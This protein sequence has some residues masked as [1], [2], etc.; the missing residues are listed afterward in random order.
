MVAAPPRRKG[1]CSEPAFTLVERRGSG[2]KGSAFQSI[3]ISG[4]VAS[5]LA[6]STI[7]TQGRW[8]ER[9]RRRKQSA[10]GSGRRRRGESRPRSRRGR[11]R[12]RPRPTCPSP[13][14]S[15]RHRPCT[16]SRP[17]P[18]LPLSSRHCLAGPGPLRRA[19][20]HLPPMRGL[21]GPRGAGEGRR[22]PGGTQ[23]PAGSPGRPG[24]KHAGGWCRPFPAGLRPG[25][26]GDPGPLLA[27][28]PMSSW[29][30]VSGGR[31]APPDGV[32]RAE[33]H[34]G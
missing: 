31:R 33:A 22:P 15:R 2:R 8:P 30:R 9:Q 27:L 19:R 3:D 1:R 21:R 23:Y 26:T 11:W 29:P 17:S 5:S 24:R 18:A 7:E 25:G 13:A 10:Q 12:H 4:L 34:Q 16:L 32:T 28:A 14:F 6:D 20:L